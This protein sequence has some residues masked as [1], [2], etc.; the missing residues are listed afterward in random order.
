M[1][2]GPGMG[3]M[4]RFT[5]PPC[6]RATRVLTKS[7]V[8]P[9]GL[10]EGHGSGAPRAP[11]LRPHPRMNWLPTIVKSHVFNE[12]P[13]LTRACRIAQQNP[14]LLY[15]HEKRR[16]RLKRKLGSFHNQLTMQG[17]VYSPWT[18]ASTPPRPWGLHPQKSHTFE[19]QNPPQTSS[20]TLSNT[21]ATSP[22]AA[23]WCS[24]R[25]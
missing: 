23:P 19:E 25:L 20:N 7:R 15:Q 4:A 1:A 21:T 24:S 12:P 13:V 6:G 5:P 9:E 2:R 10:H 18:S 3:S 11:R 8:S 22:A 16:G 17:T 14:G